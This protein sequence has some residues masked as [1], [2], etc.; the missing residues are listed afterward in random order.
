L[1]NGESANLWYEEILPQETVFYTII[2][3]EDNNILTNN[4]TGKIVQIGANATIGYG[5]C[6]FVKLL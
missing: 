3:V 5:Y 2:L 4:L 6:R 1:E